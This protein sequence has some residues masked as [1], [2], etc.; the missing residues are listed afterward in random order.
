MTA[1]VVSGIGQGAQFIPATNEQQGMLNRGK[2]YLHGELDKHPRMRPELRAAVVYALA[3]AGDKGLGAA[4]DAQWSRRKDLQPEALAM[5]GLAMLQVQDR[6][7][8]EVASLL[9][10]RA[11]RQGELVSWK[12]SYVPML[13]SEYSNDAESTAYVVRLLAK[14]R[15][16]QRVAERC[17]AV[18]Y[19]AAQRRRMVGLDRADSDGAV[20][21]GRLSCGLA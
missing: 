19:A 7:A 10:S 17:G 20:R 8:A 15:S 5:T 6:R 3:E 12:S 1:Y 11:V 9:T 4:L 16:E 2:A 13:D 18:A 14:G 21:P